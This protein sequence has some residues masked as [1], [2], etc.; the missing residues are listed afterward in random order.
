MYLQGDA[1]IDLKNIVV[2]FEGRGKKVEAVRDVTLHIEKGEIFGIVG[3]SGA[4]KSTLLRTIN[5]L[6]RPTSGEVW[7][8]GRNITGLTNGELRKVRLKVGMVFQHF[9]LAGSRTVFDNVA[10]P[11]KAAGVPKDKIPS[12][13]RALLSLVDLA[14]KENAYPGQLSGGQKQRVGIARALA[15]D[16]DILLCDEPTSALDLE[17][18]VSILELLADLNKR[19]GVT[20]III[21]HEMNVI[22]KICRRVAVLKDGKLVEENDVYTLFATPREEF[23]RQLVAQSL[24]LVLSPR[25][26]EKTRGR[27]FRVVYLGD[28]AEEPVIAQTARRHD[29]TVNILH[30]KIEYIDDRPIGV[31]FIAINGE[32][33]WVRMAVEFISHKVASIEEIRK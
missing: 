19:L 8:N 23:T 10:L 32:E 1:M 28:N 14:D 3:T 22:K 18:S 7:V 4:G 20:I 21:S 2:T 29:V 25:V 15:N 11:L 13:V 30:G 33:D 27:I 26:I 5:L 31:F 16:S 12:R 17:T 24:N 9:N 6:E